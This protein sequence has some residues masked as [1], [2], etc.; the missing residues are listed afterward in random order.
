MSQFPHPSSIV[1]YMV[2]SI[3][4]C[5]DYV[6]QMSYTKFMNTTCDSEEDSQLLLIA[7]L[8]LG[9]FQCQIYQWS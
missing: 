8:G 4:L 2:D 3:V 1:Y 5:R 6:C 7:A 9:P